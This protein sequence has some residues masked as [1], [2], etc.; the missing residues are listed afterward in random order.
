MGLFSSSTRTQIGVSV[1]R[2]IGDEQLPDS[3]LT[4]SLRAIFSGKGQYAEHILEDL[5]SGVGVKAERMYRYAKNNYTFGLPSATILRSNDGQAVAEQALRQE[6]GAGITVDYSHFGPLNNLHLAWMKLV[7]NHGYDEEFNTLNILGA[8]KNFPVYLKDMVVVVTEATLA[9]LENGSLDQW[10]R[11]P[12]AGQTPHRPSSMAAIN[13]LKKSVNYALD[14][15]AASEYVRVDWVGLEPVTTKIDPDN[16]ELDAPTITRQVV[17]EGLFY[18]PITGYDVT[19]DYF[20]IKYYL[21]GKAAYWTYMAGT[22]T[23]PDVDSVFSTE[24]DGLGSFFPVLYFRHNKVS[25]DAE[26]STEGYAT[27]KKLAKTL[28]IDYA[29]LIESIN[30]NPDIV[31][32]EQAMMMM[33]VPADST[34]PMDLRYLYEFFESVYFKSGGSGLGHAYTFR[35]IQALFGSA[36]P[37]YSI[38]VQDARF[39]SVLTFSDLTKRRVAGT[40]GPIGTY[41]TFESYK[42]ISVEV[43]YHNEQAAYTQYFRLPVQHYRKQITDILYDEVQIVELSLSYYVQ[44][45]YTKVNDGTADL[46][47]VPLDKSITE[48]YAMKDRETVYSRAMHYVFTSRVVTKVAWYQSG[49]F[50]FVM[51]VGSIALAVSSFGTSAFAGA[52]AAGTMTVATFISLAASALFDYILYTAATTVFVRVVGEEAALITSLIMIAYVGFKGYQTG[53]V[54]GVPWADELMDAA[55]NINKAINTSVQNSL[56]GLQAE[57]EEF[58]L[59]VDSETEALES[60]RAEL[61]GKSSLSSAI[62]W[63]ETPDNFYNRTVHA[64]NV[65]I[66]SIDAISNYVER[67]LALPTIHETLGDRFNGFI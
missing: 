34:D 2:V 49:F 42:E 33:G 59:F 38:V 5:V 64:G 43:P 35:E 26:A 23:Y 62:V 1:S 8:E 10:G 7:D 40:I 56:L 53:S 25:M 47:L 36:A 4:G 31:D 60:A 15:S 18:I 30:A 20:Q 22:G 39:K 6:K 55:S 66:I 27:S 63:G 11:S 12:S 67:S 32:V 3:V 17:R 14:T 50:Q 19:Q 54:K 21:E 52:I 65:G 45:H 9:E 13:R 29:D 61:E 41:G 16:E 58:R 51:L 24:F 48:L 28:G 46:L 37:K 57:A 44:G